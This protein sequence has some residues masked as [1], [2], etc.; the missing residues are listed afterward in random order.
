MHK[1]PDVWHDYLAEAMSW[2]E[3]TTSKPPARH[4]CPHCGAPMPA[5]T[6]AAPEQTQPKGETWRDRPP[7][8]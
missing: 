4:A 2:L 5:S 6:P 3:S 7:L 8:S 1:Q